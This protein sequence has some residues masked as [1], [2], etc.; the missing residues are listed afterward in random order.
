[1]TVKLFFKTPFRV[2]KQDDEVIILD[3]NIEE[4]SRNITVR[5]K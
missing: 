3:R 4:F 5:N 1:M 2:N